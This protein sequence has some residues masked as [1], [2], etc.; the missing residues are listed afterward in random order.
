MGVP[1]KDREFL[2][3]FKSDVALLTSMQIASLTGYDKKMVAKRLKMLEKLG[4]IRR[5]GKSGNKVIWAKQ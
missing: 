4:H 3:Y 2:K 5:A 1:I